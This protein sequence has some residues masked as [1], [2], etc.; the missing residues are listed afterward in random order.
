MRH[1]Q[2][3]G[4]QPGNPGQ[5]L[6]TSP[7]GVAAWGDLTLD[8]LTDV[9]VT[10]NPPAAGDTLVWDPA[11]GKY[12]PGSPATPTTT[13]QLVPLTTTIGGVPE[14]VWDDN[15]NLVMTEVPA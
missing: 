13:T 8:A 3:H 14:L 9:D 12:V 1:T 11:A 6:L 2:P 15:D 7:A 5:T 10:T 4:I